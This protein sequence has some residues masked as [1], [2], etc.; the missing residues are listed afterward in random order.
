MMQTFT[1]CKA[2]SRTAAA[3]SGPKYLTEYFLGSFSPAPDPPHTFSAAP[4]HSRLRTFT[5]PLPP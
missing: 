1:L 3:F 2:F 5:F 4:P